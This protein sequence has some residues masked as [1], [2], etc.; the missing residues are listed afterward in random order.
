MN[1][2]SEQGPSFPKGKNQILAETPPSMA[3]PSH[4]LL[5]RVCSP[6]GV[7]FHLFGSRR[8]EGFQRAEVCAKVWVVQDE[9]GASLGTA[10]RR[11]LRT[12]RRHPGEEVGGPLLPSPAARA[13]SP[14]RF[15][16]LP[17]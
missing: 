6:D 7:V 2:T 11:P 10:R 16:L 5:F 17:R 8:D 15:Q 9:S 12:A 14:G 13:W 1:L 3:V 4:L